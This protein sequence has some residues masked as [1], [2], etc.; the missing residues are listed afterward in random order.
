MLVFGFRGTSRLNLIR[1]IAV[2]CFCS[3]SVL[4]SRIEFGVCLFF[5]MVCFV[6]G[7][8][9]V[10]LGVWFAFVW[11]LVFRIAFG[12]GGFSVLSGYYFLDGYEI[13]R[14][15]RVV[16]WDYIVECF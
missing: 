5:V 14:E 12:I 9:R 10:V 15:C 16:F 11:G 7:W 13:I 4:F 3:R 2:I 1:F 6:L 8:W